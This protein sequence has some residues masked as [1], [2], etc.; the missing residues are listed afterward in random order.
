MADPVTISLALSAGGS[1][2]GA[3]QQVSAGQIAQLESNVKS[4]Q[5]ETAAASREA[6]RKDALA[7]ASASQAAAAGASGIQ[8]EGSPLSILE[9]DIRKEEQASQRDIFQTRI[10]SQAEQARGS[11]QRR[12]ATGKAITGLLQS[13]QQ[14]AGLA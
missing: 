4:K 1:L 6:D 3:S 13:G 5:I 2:L 8:F 11:V 10:T 7:E 14:L 9:E 12:L